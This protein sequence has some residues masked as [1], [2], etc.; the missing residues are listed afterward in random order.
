MLSMA[1]GNKIRNGIKEKQLTQEKLIVSLE[2]KELLST[3]VK[4]ELADKVQKRTVQ[5]E[6]QKTSLE[7][8]NMELLELKGKLYKMNEALDLANHKL[9]K[10]IQSFSRDKILNKEISFEAFQEIYKDQITCLNYLKELKNNKKMACSNCGSIVFKPKD[11]YTKICVKCKKIESATSN[12]IFHSLKF[13]LAKAFY[14]VY[15]T[16]YNK[17]KFTLDQLSDL[18]ELGRN[19]CWSFTKKVEEKK[20][21]LCKGDKNHQVSFEE[22]IL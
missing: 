16:N 5:L 18:L 22:L 7:K 12:T 20:E 9:T 6:E 13:P 17:N 15:I 21:A 3:K 14:L 10:E 4:R 19:T 11:K 8:T 1:V 2:E